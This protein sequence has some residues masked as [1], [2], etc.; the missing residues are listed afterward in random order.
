MIDMTNFYQENPQGDILPLLSED[1]Q[2]LKDFFEKGKKDFFKKGNIIINQ[3]DTVKKIYFLSK[4]KLKITLLSD[5]G[6]EK[7]FWYAYPHTIF[8][9]VPFFCKLPC[10]G[11]IIAEEDCEV[12]SHD[13]DSFY[14]ILYKN[15][16]VTEFFLTTMAKKIQILTGQ[17]K[18]ISYSNPST[19]I[20][21]LLYSLAK[22][23]GKS[24]DKGIE[25]KLTI[26]H[27][28]IAFITGLHRVTVTNVMNKLK[29]DGIIEVPKRGKLIII[30]LEKLYINMHPDF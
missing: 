16:K 22:Q 27:K 26:T 11:T 17:V 30:D 23:F 20:N 1:H 19:R 5:T 13:F 4:G 25:L 10:N 21:K 9:E 14:Q 24:T 28:E 12:S 29:K 18:D 15:P 2:Y 6:E 8:G 7:L 3:G